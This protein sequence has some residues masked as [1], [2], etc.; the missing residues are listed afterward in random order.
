MKTIAFLILAALETV[1]GQA[2][3]SR[4]VI[5]R[6]ADAKTKLPAVMLVPWLSCDSVEPAAGPLDGMNE[7]SKRIGER[8][9]F[10]YFRVDKP[11]PCREADFERELAGYRAGLASLRKHPWVD[12]NRIVL[13]GMSNGGGILPLVADGTPVAGYIVVNGWSKTWLEH[14]LEH[15]RR[16]AEASGKSPGEVSARMGGYAELY[17]AYLVGKQTPGEI[18]RAR[19][20]LAP[21]WDG[22][23]AH[24]Y[25]RPAAFFQQLQDANLAAAW[26]RVAAPALVIYGE[27]DTIMS[28]DDHERIVAMVNRNK[29]GAARLVVIPR[30]THFVEIDG[31]FPDA[32]WTAVEQWLRAR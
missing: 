7:L 13:I 6:P 10:V 5:T 21:Y 28:R 18:V 24:Q 29:P 23:P 9:G 19:P 15:L 16:A 17:T 22:E 32:V 30:M 11:Q 25:G 8:S 3:A 4:T 2:G 1:H 14:M 31:R 12:P 20:R 26:S 27:A